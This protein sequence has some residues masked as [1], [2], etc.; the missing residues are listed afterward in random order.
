M[1]V[2]QAFFVV[3]LLLA[4]AALSIGFALGGSAF[5]A[6]LIV[7]FGGFWYFAS[8]RGIYGPETFILFGYILAAASG[9]WTGKQPEVM[10]LSVVAALGAWDLDHFLKRLRMVKRVELATGLGRDHLRRL[11][12]VEMIG[13]VVGL[14]A[15][16]TRLQ[17]GFWLAAGL[18]LVAVIVL[19]RIVALLREEPKQ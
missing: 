10:L 11:I 14:A 7:F 3:H 5:A 2:I 12:L 1:K 13:G 19:S 6:M 18:A 15:L 17:L 9:F 8:E 4:V 16:Y